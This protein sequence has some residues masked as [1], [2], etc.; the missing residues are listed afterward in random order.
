MLIAD[1]IEKLLVSSE[2]DTLLIFAPPGSAKSSYVSVALPSWYLA[3]NPTHNVLAA[4]HSIDLAGKFGRRVRNLVDEYSKTLDVELAPDNQAASQWATNA[5]G[6]YMAA[7]VGKGIAGFRADLGVVDDPFGSREDA[8]SQKIREKVWDW[9]LSDFSSRL[10]PGAKRII[11]HTRWH[12][13]DLAGRVLKQVEAGIIKGKVLSLPAIATMNDP[14]GRNPGEYLWDDPSGYDYGKFLRMRKAEV[15][16]SDWASLYQQSPVVDG[17]NV[18]KLEYWRPYEPPGGKWPMASLTIAS[19][20]GAYTEKTMNDPS[21]LTVWRC[22]TG[23]DGRPRIVLC[24]AWRKWV[25]LHGPATPRLPNEKDEDYR[26]RASKQWGLCEWIADTCTR[27]NVDRLLV[28]AKGPGISVAQELQRLYS[29][30]QWSVQLIDP[31]GQDKLARAHAVQSLF[32][33]GIIHAPNR[34]WAD[35]VKQ[36][37]AEFPAGRHDDLVDSTTQAL[38]HLR[39]IGFAVRQEEYDLAEYELSRRS[40][41]PI[42]PLYPV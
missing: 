9:Y 1:E 37:C 3:K 32:V 25:P 12:V 31:K 26:L 20:D 5:G 23:E 16:E 28:E 41:R 42:E 13:D 35:M 6:E 36:E 17:G 27:L 8:M 7:G 11:M 2:Y 33:N 40:M 30:E 10:K 14:L 4:S 29:E 22:Y 24:A 38:K 18:I 39:E 15:T 19:L 34:P 21:A